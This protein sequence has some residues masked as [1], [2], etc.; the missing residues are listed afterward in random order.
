M[1]RTIRLVVHLLLV[2]SFL[3]ACRNEPNIVG[4]WELNMAILRACAEG[5]TRAELTGAA[6]A[7]YSELSRENQDLFDVAL[8]EEMRQF[9]KWEMT[10]T[11]HGDRTV[12]I[13]STKSDSVS[14]LLGV[15]RVEEDGVVVCSF[16][17]HEVHAVVDDSILRWSAKPT[18]GE[19]DVWLPPYFLVRQ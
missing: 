16:E 11:F 4:E 15:W 19:Q 7:P 18:D 6:G 14:N 10:V 9:D 5:F 8:E 17:R 2:S 1:R 3:G 13:E 12:I